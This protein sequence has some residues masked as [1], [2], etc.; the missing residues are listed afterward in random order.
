MKRDFIKKTSLLVATLA[1]CTSLIPTSTTY[2]AVKETTS[3]SITISNPKEIV[4]NY[5]QAIKSHDV[6]KAVS[7]LRE[8]GITEAQQKKDL[9]DLLKNSDTQ[10][11]S[12]KDVTLK[13]ETSTGATL[14][15]TFQ[16]GD[17]SVI[18]NPVNLE[19]D[20]GK[21]KFKRMTINE[22]PIKKATTNHK[23]N[24]LKSD[25][26]TE[27]T[28]WDYSAEHSGMVYYSDTFSA[29][30]I[31]H[32]TA[33]IWSGGNVSLSVVDKGYF[34]DTYLTEIESI[35]GNYD[36]SQSV[37]LYINSGSSVRNAQLKITYNQGCRTY[38]EIYAL[39]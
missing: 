29:Q 38:G 7:I 14:N 33:N 37:D 16:C 12:I 5:L 23:N 39:S 21:Y 10:I 6:D 34:N 17:G 19:K 13:N 11:T 31:D 36:K 26:Q 8:D 25:S 1:I 4:T 18:Q 22:A 9:K 32:F 28:N 30:N 27:L 20:N 3:A 2:A 15:V 24:L 35:S